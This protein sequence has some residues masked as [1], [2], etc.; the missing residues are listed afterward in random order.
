MF[1]YYERERER[2]KR[3][4]KRENRERRYLLRYRRGGGKSER[5]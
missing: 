2:K 5:G 1:H 4:R 3:E